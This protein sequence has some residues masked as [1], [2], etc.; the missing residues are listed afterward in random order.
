MSNSLYFSTCLS[1]LLVLLSNFQLYSQSFEF[2]LIGDMPYH[3]DDSVK[4]ENLIRDINADDKLQWIMHT[5][6]IKEGYEVCSDTYLQNRFDWY[7]KFEHPFIITPGDNEW[8]DCHR[9][10]DEGYYAPL[11]RLS[12]LREIFFKNPTQS[13]GQRKIALRSQSTQAE[14][15]SF[16]EHQAW[17]KSGVY[18]ATMHMVG[19]NNG[20]VQFEGRTSADDLEVASR[21]HAAIAWMKET[22]ALADQDGK[23]VFLMI[24]ANPGWFSPE[25]TLQGMA[26]RAFGEFIRELEKCVIKFGRP[27][28]LAHGDS[29]YFR[30]DKPLLNSVTKRRIEMFTRLEGFGDRDIHWLKIH[31]DPD[32]PMVFQVRQELVKENF[33]EH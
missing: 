22:F 20:W 24:H 5:G 4:F 33:E 14:F 9:N 1:M 13:L 31:V 32:D 10:R 30:L 12:K 29:H 26:E 15:Q 27:V 23:G 19:S 2:A 18:F 11:E 28:I 16:P 25:D 17:E 7:A 6:D 8:T 21:T 3:P